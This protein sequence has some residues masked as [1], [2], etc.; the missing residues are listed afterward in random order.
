MGLP[1]P[2]WGA[3]DSVDASRVGEVATEGELVAT[4]GREITKRIESSAAEST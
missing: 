1:P 3:A 2:V 4:T